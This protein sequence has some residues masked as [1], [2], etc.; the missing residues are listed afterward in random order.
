MNPKEKIKNI[1]KMLFLEHLNHSHSGNISILDQNTI[2]ITKSGSMLFDLKDTDIVSGS[3]ENPNIKDASME[4]IVHRAIYLKTNFRAIVHCHPVFSILLS[5]KYNYIEPLDAE[6]KFYFK[7]IPV[8]STKNPIASCEVAEKIP[9]FF[10]DSPVVIV[11]GH[12]VFSAGNTLDEAYKYASSL[13][14]SARIYY[15]NLLLNR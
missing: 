6:G 8:L 5:L 15:F 3:I 10:K 11:K 12:G 9:S 13:E 7:C 2:F 1:G 4:Y 14:T